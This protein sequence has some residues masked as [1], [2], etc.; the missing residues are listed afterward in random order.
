MMMKN[1]WTKTGE[2]GTAILNSICDNSSES[3]MLS[4]IVVNACE[5]PEIPENSDESFVTIQAPE[6][7]PRVLVSIVGILA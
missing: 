7:D 3:I 6:S 2:K 5:M 1:A 4:D